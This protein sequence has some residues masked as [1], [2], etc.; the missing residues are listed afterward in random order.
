[1]YKWP[2]DGKLWLPGLKNNI[3][4][5]KLWV[6]GEYLTL[7]TAKEGDWTAI[8]LPSQRPEKL[9]SVI[10][11][12]VEGSPEVDA[13]LSLDLVFATVLPVDFATPE[14][15][16]IKEKRWMEKFGKWKHIK[17]AQDWT[18]KGAVSWALMVTEPGYYQTELNYAGS[19]A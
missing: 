3:I 19:A 1:M 17:Q 5:A 15:C 13:R 4:F 6:N 14:A 8:S 9:I 18:D 12:E 7:K 16:S 11:L 2:L 10:E